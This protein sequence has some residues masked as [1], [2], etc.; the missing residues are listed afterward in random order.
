M[1]HRPLYLTNP[2]AFPLPTNDWWTDALLSRWTGS[3]WSYPALVRAGA[4]GVSVAFPSF[5]IDNGTEMKAKSRLVFGAVGFNPT[6]ANIDGWHDWDVELRLPEGEKSIK[7][8]LVH[9]SPFTWLEYDG[10]APTIKIEAD[11]GV[12]P[13]SL[14]V[15][16][17]SGISSGARAPE[18]SVDASGWLVKV[19]DD[20]YGIWASPGVRLAKG[21]DGAI[22]V[23]G[24]G[25][26]TWISVGLL[27]DESA[28]AKLAPYA[29]S[30]IRET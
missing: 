4:F 24:A 6:A 26:K 14:G 15:F 21:D 7:A 10:L 30:I 1:Q 19:G 5:W 9:G 2:K 20:R 29:S 22:R 3:L 13:G 25:A 12:D 18:D 23:T 11:D 17:A 8:T 28:F 16:S 27:P